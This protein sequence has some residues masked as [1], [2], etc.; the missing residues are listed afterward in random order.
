MLINLSSPS[1]GHKTDSNHSYPDSS[2]LRLRL[3]KRVSLFFALATAI[4]LLLRTLVAPI[5]PLPLLINIG[6][7]LA[8]LLAYFAARSGKARLA[9]ST[10]LVS[11]TV[12]ILV[13]GYMAGALSAPVLAILPLIPLTACL[14]IGP[15]AG[16]L[17]SGMAVLALAVLAGME[18]AGVTHPEIE[19]TEH[20]ARLARA[21]MLS[22]TCVL[23]TAIVWYYELLQ[24]RLH[25]LAIHDPLTGIANRGYFDRQLAHEWAR[26]MRST[27][28][29][30]LLMLDIDQFKRYNDDFG[31]QAGDN[32]IISLAQ[33]ITRQSRRVTD[34]FA[35]YGGEEFVLIL[36]GAAEEDACK[37]AELLRQKVNDLKIPHPTS[38]H[39]HV[40]VSMGIA[41]FSSASPLTASQLVSH[42]DSALYRA[43][44]SG[45]NKVVI[46]Q[47]QQ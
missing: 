46:Y 28:P 32:C 21:I 24:K 43:K 3:A 1:S 11:M 31:H 41:T 5:S 12:L 42:A 16:W 22:I 40:T 44:A 27:E 4:G 26:A 7:L 25:T 36:P 2:Y 19:L 13:T 17:C 45:R 18:I 8:F 30:S 10:T 14:L 35:R 37:F 33:T 20:Q 47:P 9:S 29:V 15:N 6:C 39:G 34:F 23:A 38:Q